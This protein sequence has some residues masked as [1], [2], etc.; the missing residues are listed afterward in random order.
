VTLRS[1][2]PSELIPGA[3]PELGV[4]EETNRHAPDA[5]EA[6]ARAVGGEVAALHGFAQ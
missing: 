4:T 5:L 3:P 1:N 2:L 6:V